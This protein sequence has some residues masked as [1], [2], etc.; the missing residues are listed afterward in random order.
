MLVEALAQLPSATCAKELVGR[1]T[2]WER[3]KLQS[4]KKD[5]PSEIDA[6]RRSFH[7]KMML[8]EV[9]ALANGESGRD[10]DRRSGEEIRR[11]IK[12]QLYLL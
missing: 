8:L 10:T 5:V 11:D 1:R 7:P 2:D 9:V 12:R 3:P 4:R 6:D